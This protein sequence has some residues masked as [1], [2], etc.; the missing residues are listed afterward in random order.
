[1]PRQIDYTRHYARWHDGSDAHLAAMV[2]DFSTLL[3]PYL[4][5][6]KT[7]PILEIGCGMG[8][9]L[10][11]LKEAGYSNIAGF[12]SDAGQIMAARRRGLPADLVR[13][14]DTKTFLAERRERYAFI[15]CIDVLEHIPIDV[16]LDFLDGIRQCLKPGGTL[17]CRVPNANSPMASRYRYIDW[18]HHCSFT[19][20]SLDFVLFNA[21]FEPIFVGEAETLSRPRYPFIPRRATL[22]W[23]LRR[24]FRAV[25]RVELVCEVG[26]KDG[27]SIPLGLNILAHARRPLQPQE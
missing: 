16:Q 8:F 26:P 21:G 24:M 6:D 20:A 19:E 9:A 25:R 27:W 2:A 23:L 14:E 10:A 4:P 5:A 7:A 17:L 18:T 3:S 1:M 12:D 13:V 22:L 15:F 11:A